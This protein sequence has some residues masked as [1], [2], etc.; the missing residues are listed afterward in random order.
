MEM[1]A[2]PAG[3]TDVDGWADRVRGHGLWHRAGGD[4]ELAAVRERTVALVSR[5][6]GERRDGL[7][8]VVDDPWQDRD[9]PLRML[10]RSA[11]LVDLLPPA[12]LSAREVAL[13]LAVPFLYDTLWSTLAGRE[14]GV[15]PHDLTPSPD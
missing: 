10:E 15:G 11:W 2:W 13:L 1:D 7:F 4:P 9:F 12:E 5:L 6:A 14:R 3:P 8:A